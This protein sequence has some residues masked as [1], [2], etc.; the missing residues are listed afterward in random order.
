MTPDTPAMSELKPCPFCGTPAII[1]KFPSMVEQKWQADC[2]NEFCKCS[3]SSNA[4]RTEEEARI[5]WN[6]RALSPQPENSSRG[7]N[8]KLEIHILL[9]ALV[10]AAKGEQIDP[11]MCQTIE[12]IANDW[13]AKSF[14]KDEL[15]ALYDCGSVAPEKV[16]VLDEAISRVEAVF[17]K[18]S[19]RSH[20]T[21]MRTQVNGLNQLDVYRI[22]E[23]ARRYARSEP[24]ITLSQLKATLEWMKKV[25][26][27]ENFHPDNARQRWDAATQNSILDAAYEAAEKAVKS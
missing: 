20:E 22:I 14:G 9:D 18:A 23:A 16:E 2:P 11:E 12:S 17:D 3:P 21:G 4:H 26:P 15:Q 1:E 10:E 6:T 25:V 5:A 19:D 13:N 24:S 8:A 27:D 7:L